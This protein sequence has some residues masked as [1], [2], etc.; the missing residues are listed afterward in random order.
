MACYETL[1]M[2]LHDIYIL[3]G[4]KKKTG[5]KTRLIFSVALGNFRRVSQTFKNVDL[6]HRVHAKLSCSSSGSFSP[7][8][9]KGG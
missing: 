2:A 8:S 3:N 1:V 9:I 4:E 6:S 7:G 5:M